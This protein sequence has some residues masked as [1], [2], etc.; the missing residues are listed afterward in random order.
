MASNAPTN[1]TGLARK[2]VLDQII[3]EFNPDYVF[4]ERVGFFSS[5]ILKLKIPLIIFL[6]GDYWS[7]TKIAKT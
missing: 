6:R 4:T 3:D 2:F 7:E 5:C 1:L